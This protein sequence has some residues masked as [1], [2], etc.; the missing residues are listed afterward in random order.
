MSASSKKKLRNEQEAAKMTERQLAEQKEAKKLKLYTTIFTVVLAAIVLFAL[1]SGI[2]QTIVNSGIRERSTVAVTLG[3]EELNNAELNY[4]FIDAVNE[5]YSY[6]GTYAA[7]FGLDVTAPL[8]EQITND[9]TGDTWADDFE[10]SA[11][12]NAQ[13][14]VAL[15]LEAKANG[16]TLTEDEQAEIDADLS[17]LEA[18]AI[19]YGFTEGEDYLKALFGQGATVE[20]YREYLETSALANSYY[21]YYSENLTYTDAD[22]RAK[23][24]ENYDQFSS[25]SYNYYYM[26]SSRFLT[27]GT[28]GEDD[29]VTYSD[30]EKAASVTACEDAAKTLAAEQIASVEAFDAAIAALEINADSET[31]PSSTAANDVMYSSVMGTLQEWVTASERKVGDVAYIASESTV[32]DE[33][34]NESTTVNGYYVV[35]FNGKNDN[36]FALANVR[37]VLISFEGG[38]YDSNTGVTTYSDE[39]K[40]AAKEKAEALLADFL[41]GKATELDFETLAN[42]NSADSDGTDGGLYE[43]VYPGQ[44]VTNFNDWCFDESRQPGDTGIVESEYG[45]HIMFYSSDS[46]TTYRDYL[47]E[48]ELR[49]AD[50]SAWYSAL[51]EATPITEGNT[52]YLSK[53]L[54]LSGN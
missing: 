2:S 9:E 4:Y 45:Y 30:E 3:D 35:Y 5:F 39:E 34:G 19:L 31:A 1:Y 13:A 37:H 44:M 24:E 6:Y 32:T 38:T 53:D 25:Y 50:T 51:I 8:N 23:E 47:I 33:E 27:G 16:F 48:K 54:I 15:A 21:S 11:V 40:A 18:Y 36:A 41:D 7:M 29:I 10:D 28:T 46:E 42:E 52:K 26:A 22:L 49:S 20:S 17:S 14:T 43:N 12:S